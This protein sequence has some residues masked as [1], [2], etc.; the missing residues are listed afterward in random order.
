M[1]LF[2]CTY[3][4]I[5]SSNVSFPPWANVQLLITGPINLMKKNICNPSIVTTLP[6]MYLLSFDIWAVC[7]GVVLCCA[8]AFAGWCCH[9]FE[10]S[11]RFLAGACRT[12]GRF[13]LK[14]FVALRVGVEVVSEQWTKC[15][16]WELEISRC[17]HRSLV[18]LRWPCVRTPHFTYIELKA[19]A[20]FSHTR[21]GAPR[22][23]SLPYIMRWCVAIRALKTTIQLLLLLRSSSVSARWGMLTFNSLVQWIRSGGAERGHTQGHMVCAEEVHFKSHWAAWL[24]YDLVA[25]EQLTNKRNG[26]QTQQFLTSVMRHW[27][28]GRN[29]QHWLRFPIWPGK[30]QSQRKWHTNSSSYLIFKRFYVVSCNMIHLRHFLSSSWAYHKIPIRDE[31]NF[32]LML[33]L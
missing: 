30:C 24:C 18:V 26:G 7:S 5:H 15:H 17:P 6:V 29:R 32:V 21:L 8:V 27:C 23:T 25:D 28:T 11:A 4:Q 12:R 33:S 10:M 13:G 19:D 31:S 9:T 2:H 22:L 1:F 14:A 20:P 3:I 16:R